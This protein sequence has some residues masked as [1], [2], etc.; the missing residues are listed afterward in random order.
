M[1][2]ASVLVRKNELMYGLK[3]VHRATSQS[4]E[5]QILSHVRMTTDGWGLRLS[6]TDMLFGVTTWVPATTVVGQLDLTVPLESLHNCVQEIQSGKMLITQDEGAPSIHIHSGRYDVRIR[7]RNAQDFPPMPMISNDDVT[8]RIEGRI[9]ADALRD[10][11]DKVAIAAAIEDSRPELT[12]VRIECDGSRATFVAAD[13]FR[14]AIYETALDGA[15]AEPIYFNMPAKAI[16]EIARLSQGQAEPIEFMYSPKRRRVHWQLG[17]AGVM[18]EPVRDTYPDYRKLIP[19]SWGTRVVVAHSE[20]VGALEF[21]AGIKTNSRVGFQ[22][23]ARAQRAF[24]LSIGEELARVQIE[25]AP[26]E[27]LGRDAKIA[28]NG[29]YLSDAI[30]GIGSNAKVA[31]V[32]IELTDDSRPLVIRP[33]IDPLDHSYLHVVMPMFVN[34]EEEG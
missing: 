31:E 33:A 16:Q 15:V 32:A 18:A 19:E 12:C 27:F 29:K 9:K 3:D 26:V 17:T 6:A 1:A 30:D 22:F 34:W 2:Q 25:I 8:E 7:G 5:I 23:D 11:A 21:L 28:M 14:L 13:G 10:V 4:L 20:L 24:M